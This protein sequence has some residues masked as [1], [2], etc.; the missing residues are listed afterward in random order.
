[1]AARVIQPSPLQDLSCRFWQDDEPV[2]INADKEM[3]VVTAAAVTVDGMPSKKARA[4]V[5]AKQIP[6]ARSRLGVI[7]LLLDQVLFTV[8]KH[9]FIL[10]V[11]LNMVGLV[12]VANGHFLYARQH[13]ADFGSS[14]RATS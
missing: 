7:L 5:S 8:Y 11:L 4:P 3:A 12:L 1:M 10:C 13:S 2:I 9:L 14:P 6:S